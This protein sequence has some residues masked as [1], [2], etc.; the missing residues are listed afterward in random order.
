MGAIISTNDPGKFTV[1]RDVDPSIIPYSQQEELTEHDPG[2][3]VVDC[4]LTK[5]SE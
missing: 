1:S 4:K 5:H 2:E 3:T